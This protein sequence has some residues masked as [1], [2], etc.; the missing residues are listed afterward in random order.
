MEDTDESTVTLEG[1]EERT[2]R[3]T[4]AVETFLIGLW[5]VLDTTLDFILWWKQNKLAVKPTKRQYFSPELKRS[6]GVEQ[7]RRCMYCGERKLLKNLQIDHKYPVDRG[8]SNDSSN[9]QLLCRPCNL[10]K[11]IHTDEEF[12]SR[13]RELVGPAIEGKLA[14]PP[15]KVIAQSQFVAVTRETQ[16]A[17]AVRAHRANKYMTPRQ[18]IHSGAPVIAGVVGL[19]WFFGFALVF[20]D[21]AFF[22]NVAVFGGLILAGSIWAGLIFRAR[23]TGRFDE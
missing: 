19:V 18:R 17:A 16:A 6:L 7:D 10:R 14:R 3:L 5:F 1:D 2:S 8:G 9:L 21:N 20:P 22:A 11:G 4:Q 13:Y 12:R 23:Y 15:T